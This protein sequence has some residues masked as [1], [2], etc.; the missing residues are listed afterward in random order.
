[1]VFTQDLVK[2]PQVVLG[3]GKQFWFKLSILITGFHPEFAKL[4]AII[5]DHFIYMYIPSYICAYCGNPA[6]FNHLHASTASIS[7]KS[8]LMHNISKNSKSPQYI[9]RISCEIVHL[10]PLIQ[11]T[12]TFKNWIKYRYQISFHI[13]QTS[14]KLSSASFNLS[15]HCPPI[16]CGLE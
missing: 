11:D 14:W 1:M 4:Q 3:R 2:Y 7:T 13:Y 5:L 16:K 15:K 8:K 12:C 9:L 6:S 10:S